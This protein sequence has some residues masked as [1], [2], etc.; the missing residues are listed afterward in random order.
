[1]L[2]YGANNANYFKLFRKHGTGFDSFKYFNRWKAQLLFQLLEE[3]FYFGSQIEQQKFY[4]FNDQI[5]TFLIGS[6]QKNFFLMDFLKS[7]CFRK[8]RSLN[9]E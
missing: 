7:V 5:K 8:S 9:F 1:M 4:V 6:L 2:S 3:S